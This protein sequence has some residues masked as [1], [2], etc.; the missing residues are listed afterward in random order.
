[1]SMKRK[2]YTTLGVADS[3]HVTHDRGTAD[4]MRFRAHRSQ[5]ERTPP[6]IVVSVGGLLHVSSSAS[7]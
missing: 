5:N 3:E 4:V 6:Q 2:S 1:M 7:D